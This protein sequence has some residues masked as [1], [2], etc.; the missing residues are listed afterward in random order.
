MKNKIN[1]K[2]SKICTNCKGVGSTKMGYWYVSG[3]MVEK[4]PITVA[5]CRYCFG[6]GYLLLS[7]KEAKKYKVH[8][9][10]DLL[11]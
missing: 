1:Y 9:L 3:D 4:T 2:I 8:W 6:A 10:G 5:P 7:D 11:R